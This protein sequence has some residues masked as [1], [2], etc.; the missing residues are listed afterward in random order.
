[1]N[2]WIFRAAVNCVSLMLSAACQTGRQNQATVH[3]YK[4]REARSIHVG[5][6]GHTGQQALPSNTARAQPI[7]GGAHFTPA[8]FLS[9]WHPRPSRLDWPL[10]SDQT[11]EQGAE[12]ERLALLVR[13]FERNR[14]ST[15][16]QRPSYKAIVTSCRENRGPEST[17]PQHLVRRPGSTQEDGGCLFTDSDSGLCPCELYMLGPRRL[18]AV[19]GTSPTHLQ[20]HPVE[21][22]SAALV[23]GKC[24]K[25]ER[26]SAFRIVP[27]RSYLKR[28]LCVLLPLRHSVFRIRKV[29]SVH[30]KVAAAASSTHGGRPRLGPKCWSPCSA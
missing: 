23:W 12:P 24:L 26:F 4:V 27:R 10:M 16:W 19:T 21:K 22:I 11:R 1:M 5:P 14:L 25:L 18:L 8:V 29:E 17:G 7:Y 13:I 15:R 20:S 30:A 3:Q 9:A 2:S 28:V 6:R